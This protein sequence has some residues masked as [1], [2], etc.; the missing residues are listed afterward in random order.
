MG[1]TQMRRSRRAL[2]AATMFGMVGGSLAT[3]GTANAAVMVSGSLVDSAGNYAEGYVYAYTTDGV[4]A[5]SDYASNG[6]FDIP[7]ADGTYKLE[8][9][10][11]EYA[12]EWYRDK[13]DEATA[14]VITVAGAGQTLAPWTVDHLPFVKGVVRAPDG[15]G[16]SSGDVLAYDAATNTYIDEVETRED[17]SFTLTT[18][19]P[20]VKL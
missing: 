3:M 4:P 16:V 9:S 19:T 12:D 7:L 1:H 17:G 13:A 20:S 8:Y 14:D 18:S 6:V 5:G 10:G 2:A 15:R 11:F